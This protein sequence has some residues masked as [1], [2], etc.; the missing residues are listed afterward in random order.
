MK[1]YK[2]YFI[3]RWEDMSEIDFLKKE[4]ELLKKEIELLK[5]ELSFQP[6]A[7]ELWTIS[8]SKYEVGEMDCA[9]VSFPV[10]K[11]CTSEERGSSSKH[12]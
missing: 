9:H 1:S 7:Q 10:K 8:F 12:F 4:I 5:K 2:C 11:Y 6:K 3:E